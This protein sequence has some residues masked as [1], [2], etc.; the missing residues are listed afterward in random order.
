MKNP[1]LG[2]AGSLPIFNLAATKQID[3]II[4]SFSMDRYIDYTIIAF[5]IIAAAYTAWV[6]IDGMTL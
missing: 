6:I 2:G 1:A 4:Y 5:S 3:S